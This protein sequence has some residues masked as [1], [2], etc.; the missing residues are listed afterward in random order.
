VAFFSVCCSETSDKRSDASTG[1]KGGSDASGGGVSGNAAGESGTSE[2]AGTNGAG[3]TQAASESGGVGTGNVC[4]DDQTGC[5]P[6]CEGGVC[7]CYCESAGGA[8]GTDEGGSAAVGT[9]G[10]DEGGSS[11]SAATGG[12][13]SAGTAVES[14][15]TPSVEPGDP[16]YDRYEGT[17]FDNDCESDDD[18]M[19]SGCSGEVCAA[20]SV[21]TTCEVVGAPGGECGCVDKECIWHE[22]GT[23][24]TADQCNDDRGCITYSD[25]CEGC[26]CLALP[27]GDSPPECDGVIVNCFADPCMNRLVSCVDGSCVIE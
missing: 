12:G 3:G 9:G 24:V 8:A 27:A 2:T 6:I 15:E 11:G 25:Y 17:A 18:C 10:T 26:N 1:E 19:T 23:P 5:Y 4:G 21:V 22:S 16:L 7:E 20:E 14:T 13:G